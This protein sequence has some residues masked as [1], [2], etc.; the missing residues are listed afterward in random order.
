[1]S[2]SVPLSVEQTR[3]EATWSSNINQ[4]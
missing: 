4:W 1:L 2:F 3:I